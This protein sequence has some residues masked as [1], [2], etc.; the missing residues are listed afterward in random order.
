MDSISTPGT[1]LRKTGQSRFFLL[2]GG[3][4]SFSL[5]ERYMFHIVLASLRAIYSTSSSP[6][7]N[8]ASH[9]GLVSK[10]T[11]RES[12]ILLTARWTGL[13]PAT[14]RVTGGCSNQIELPPHIISYCGTQVDTSIAVLSRFGNVNL[15]I[16]TSS[17]TGYNY[18]IMAEIK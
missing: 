10:I 13:E 16:I 8:H 17:Q 9:H 6:F 3:R 7:R 11:L 2:R 18:G 5:H 15:L 12:V 14:S 4:K 1:F